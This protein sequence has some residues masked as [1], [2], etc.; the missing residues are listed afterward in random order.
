MSTDLRL[1]TQCPDLAVVL[2]VDSEESRH[3]HFEDCSFTCQYHVVEAEA[4]E[5]SKDQVQA[6]VFNVTFIPAPVGADT[7]RLSSL[8]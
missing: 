3:C 6:C 4:V 1:A 5:R 7:T 2:Q 8:K